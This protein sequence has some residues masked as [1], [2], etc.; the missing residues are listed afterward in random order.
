MEQMK[1]Y[2]HDEIW[3]ASLVRKVHQEETNWILI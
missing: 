1:L 3:I 2:T